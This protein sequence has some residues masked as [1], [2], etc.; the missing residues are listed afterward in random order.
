MLAMTADKVLEREHFDELLGAIARRGYAIVG[1]TIREQAIVYDEISSAADLPIG[2]A[3]EQD[4]GYY[5][6]RRRNDT[7]CS[8]MRSGRT[9]G[10]SFSSRLGFGSGGRVRTAERRPSRRSRW[11]RHRSPSSACAR[12]S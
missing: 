2:W 11:T 7:R 12:A 10:S 9:R 3:D 8:A 1:P 4:G 5:R 6:L